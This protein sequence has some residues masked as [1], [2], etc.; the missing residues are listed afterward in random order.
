VTVTPENAPQSVTWTS[1]NANVVT[2][3]GNGIITAI[4]VGTAKITVASAVATT[5]TDECVVTVIGALPVAAGQW[6]FE[7]TTNPTKATI[8]DALT[9]NGSSFEV[10]DAP[11]NTKAVKF[12]GGSYF[13]VPHN[14]GANG[15]GDYVN[16]YTLLLDISGSATEFA[17][18]LTVFNNKAGNSGDGVL[19]INGDGKI[20]FAELG[21]YSTVELMPDV[22]T[23]VVISAELGESF[24][25]YFDGELAFEA[26]K[27]IGVDGMMSLYPDFIYI[28]YD[29][30]GYK[31]PDLAECRMWG[32]TL[33]AEQIKALGNAGD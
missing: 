16:N 9:A 1:D 17:E 7:D 28:G 29:G 24:K 23:R 20:G 4:A 12:N 13:T 32:I 30:S 18:W 15:G 5:Q 27:N 10:I 26:T 19:W 11:N 8:G 3:D 25:V 6:T 21:G 33:P 2:V 31:G 22:W 14:I